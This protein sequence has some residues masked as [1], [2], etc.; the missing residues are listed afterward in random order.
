MSFDYDAWLDRQ[1]NEW[2]DTYLSDDNVDEEDDDF[3]AESIL[4][5]YESSF[6]AYDYAD[7]MEDAL[8]D[9]FMP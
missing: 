7:R 1:M 3:D 4:E 6:D 8:I 9:R 5:S 2:Y